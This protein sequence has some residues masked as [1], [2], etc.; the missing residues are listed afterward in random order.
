MHP[1]GALSAPASVLYVE[2]LNSA[3]SLGDNS[4]GLLE[5]W[6]LI[7]HRLPSICLITLSGLLAGIL[8]SLAQTPV[9]QARVSL[10]IQNPSESV[11]NVRIDD[12]ETDGATLSPEAYL[13]TQVQILQSLTLRQRTRARMARDK[14]QEDS[15]LATS[16]QS[17]LARLGLAPKS[18]MPDSGALP[19]VEVKMRV[20]DNTRIVEI[21]CDTKNALPDYFK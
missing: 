16:P 1:N 11:L 9:Y 19:P 10:E 2:P 21:L 12:L 17:F 7:R 6:Y 5:Y 20:A 14:T 3:P 13:P 15:P 18:H 8:V 4:S